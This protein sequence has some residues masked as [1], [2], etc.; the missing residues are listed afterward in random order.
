MNIKI[1]KY[2]NKTRD[3]IIIITTKGADLFVHTNKM[4]TVITRKSRLINY[5]TE[6]KKT[7]KIDTLF[8]R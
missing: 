3:R 4:I 1:Q 5:N 6:K 8:T 2:Y 7:P